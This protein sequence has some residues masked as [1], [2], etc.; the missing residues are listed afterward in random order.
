[1][2]DGERIAPVGVEL[3]SRNEQSSVVKFTLSEGK[4]REIRRICEQVG[5]YIT[6]LKRISLGPLRIGDLKAGEYR[7]LTGSE[8]RA[9]K[10][11]VKGNKK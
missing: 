4:N 2:L 3:V 8:L 10:N 7:E 1:M 11:A 9:L 5:V 6:K